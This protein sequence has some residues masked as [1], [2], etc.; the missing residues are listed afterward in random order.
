MDQ[1]ITP[2]KDERTYL[3]F[4][5]APYRLEIGGPVSVVRKTLH[6]TPYKQL[7][8][9][10]SVPSERSDTDGGR[11]RPTI[12]DDV[13]LAFLTAWIQWSEVPFSYCLSEHKS[14]KAKASIEEI[15]E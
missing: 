3:S 12:N 1:V 15:M 8:D 10:P 9:A 5:G 7:A 11:K 13:K 2:G 6:T 4:A 14:K